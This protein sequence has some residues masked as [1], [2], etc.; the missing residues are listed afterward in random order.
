M[1]ASQLGTR[2][3]LRWALLGPFTSLSLGAAAIHFAVTDA[4]FQEWWAFGAF[5]AAVG[6]FQAL[7]PIAYTAAPSVRLAIASVLVNL[8]TA[9][10]WALTRLVGLPFGPG[11]GRPMPV[12]V[13]D[14]IATAFELALVVGL[15]LT[16]LGPVRRA[17]SGQG[18]ASST[19][20][21]WWIALAVLVAAATSAGITI[22]MSSMP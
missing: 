16:S 9:V 18:V 12:G 15:L 19:S 2:V 11:A 21:A 22:G 4:H 3:S 20:T 13:P 10:V 7:W 6:W 8:G 1:F 14:V 17:T 5:M